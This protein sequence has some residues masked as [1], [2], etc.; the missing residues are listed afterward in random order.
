SVSL[1]RPPLLSRLV[2]HW[3]IG[4]RGHRVTLMPQLRTQVTPDASCSS[5]AG[6]YKASAE[7]SSLWSHRKRLGSTFLPFLS[8]RVRRPE[9]SAAFRRSDRVHDQLR[10]IE[11]GRRVEMIQGTPRK[12]NTS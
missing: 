1:A 5:M 3:R 4:C 8:R 6:T 7:S 2:R 9:I 11:H 10:R 12:R